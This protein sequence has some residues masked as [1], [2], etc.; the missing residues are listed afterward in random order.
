MRIPLVYQLPTWLT[1]VLFVVV[2]LAALEGG[3]RR[4]LR[5]RDLWKDADAGGGQVVL[6]SMFALLGLLLAFTYAFTVSRHEGRKH[7]VITEANAL[8][9]AFLRAGLVAEPGRSEL[10]K[11]LLDYGRTRIVPPGVELTDAKIRELIH[12]SVQAQAKL[13]PATE[14]I[15]HR[16][17]PGP[18]EASL[19]AAINE[20]IDMHTIRAVA[21]VDRLPQV[22]LWMQ[23]F[24]A[25]ASLAVAGFNAGL[26]GRMSRWRMTALTFVLTAVIIV[27]IDFDMPQR[28]FIRVSQE[29][30]VTVIRDMEADLAK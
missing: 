15:I 6:T 1:C 18:I 17:P 21:V 11:A 27:I 29:P 4:G 25:A 12:R 22:V 2:L 24:I 3:Y 23:L 9:T 10:K 30:L 13:W 28:G 14:R 26:S 19:V 7:A 16:K 20:V 5:R 8:G